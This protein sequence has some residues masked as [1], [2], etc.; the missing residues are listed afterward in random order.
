MGTGEWINIKNNQRI[1]ENI[2]S[3]T[4]EAVEISQDAKAGQFIH[5]LCGKEYGALLRRPFSLSTIDKK[6]RKLSI[7]YRVQGKGSKSLSE[8]KRGERI[9]A[10]GPLGKGFLLD[11]YYKNVAVVAGGMGIAPLMEVIRYYGKQSRIYLGFM[12]E[13]ILVEEIKSFTNHIQVT[14]EKGTIGRKGLITENLLSQWEENPPEIVY[15]CGPRGMMKEVAKISEELIIPCQVSMEER[16]GCGIGACLVCSCKTMK[17]NQ[18][19]EYTRVCKDG[20]VYWGS[21]VVWDE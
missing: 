18:K 9:H 19:N 11:S 16:M 5:L 7:V 17:K 12:A 14:T 2:Y 1:G 10:L 6:N 4:L 21:E 13:P 8:M 20:P 15:T 3:M